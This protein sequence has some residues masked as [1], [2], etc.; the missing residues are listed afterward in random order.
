MQAVTDGVTEHRS[1]AEPLGSATLLDGPPMPPAARPGTVKLHLAAETLR[2]YAGDWA[3]FQD[4]CAERGMTALRGQPGTGRCLSRHPR[5]GPAPPW[6]GG[7]PPS[8]I[9]TASVALPRPAPNRACGPS[10]APPAE[11]RAAANP[12]GRAGCGNAHWLSGILPRRPHRPTR[13]GAA[14]VAGCRT[15]SRRDRGA[16]GRAAAVFRT[17]ARRAR[18]P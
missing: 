11:C 18:E 4:Y 10:C 7:W 17:R 2:L 16:A 12:H 14:A 13:P 5:H 15:G 8:T 9:S 6:P 3:H 1:A